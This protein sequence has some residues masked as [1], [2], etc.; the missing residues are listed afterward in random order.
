MTHHIHDVAS[1]ELNSSGTRTINGLRSLGLTRNPFSSNGPLMQDTPRRDVLD[2]VRTWM[3]TIAADPARQDRLAVLTAEPGMGKSRLLRELAASA[4]EGISV[5]LID[6]GKGGL[7][8]VQLLRAIIDAL[9]GTATGRTGMD[10]RRDIRHA[11]ADL[12]DGIVPGVLIDDADYNGA[13]LELLR[14]VLRDGVE[15]G[16]FIILTGL[17]DL[18]D[19]LGRR[20]SLRAILGPVARLDSMQPD[21]M[22]ELIASRIDTMDRTRPLMSG[23]AIELMIELAD[24][25]P[26]HLLRLA[27]LGV[28]IAARQGADQI[29]RPSVMAAAGQMTSTSESVPNSDEA[30]RAVQAE[31]PL[32]GGESPAAGTTQRTLWDGGTSND[33]SPD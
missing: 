20:R 32:F 16:L 1:R 2:G 29:R 18:A 17:P 22:R 9:G 33:R 28:D 4:G 26:G 14:N 23:D 24:G 8:D 21:S 10:L 27:E 30:P 15:R 25:N 7:T 13:R 12:P 6:P 3:S 5:A 11:V 19:R 31:I